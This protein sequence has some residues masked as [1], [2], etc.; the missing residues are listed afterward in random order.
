MMFKTEQ[1][2]RVFE[3]YRN[4]TR[5]SEPLYIEEK[6]VGH[7]QAYLCPSNLIQCDLHCPVGFCV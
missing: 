1:Q 2:D 4:S 6:V 3:I 5:E 7:N